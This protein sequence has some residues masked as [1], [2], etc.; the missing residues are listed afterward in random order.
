MAA[1]SDKVARPKTGHRSDLCAPAERRCGRR[2]YNPAMSKSAM[3]ARSLAFAGL[4][5]LSSPTTAAHAG[6]PPIV[7]SMRERARVRDL[8]L[9]LRLERVVPALMRR[10]GIDMWIVVSREYAE[11]PVFP[12]MAPATWLATYGSTLVPGKRRA[13]QKPS[14]TAGLRCAPEMSPTA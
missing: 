8:W 12:T 14:V 11:D 13:T 4:A 7:L 5:L 9:E 3:S 2:P 10:E 6:D 1:H